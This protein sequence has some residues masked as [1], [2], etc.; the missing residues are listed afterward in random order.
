MKRLAAFALLALAACGDN[1]DPTPVDMEYVVDV[2]DAGGDCGSPPAEGARAWLDLQL[3]V[4]G[5]V[6][7]NGWV[8]GLL[9]Q[10]SFLHL[11]PEDGE[12]DADIR[13]QYGDTYRVI[14]A[15]S[16]DTMDLT[17]DFPSYRPDGSG[18]ACRQR[19]RLQGSGRAFRDPASSDGVYPLATDYF[20]SYC[21]GQPVPTVP[22]GS[23]LFRLD[24]S[25]HDGA[26]EV[27]LEHVFWF[28]GPAPGPD[29][30]VDW[31]GTYYLAGE[32]GIEE[33]PGTFKGVYAPDRVDVALEFS[34]AS[35]GPH[36]RYR[37]ELRGAKRT[38][39]L[40]AVPNAYRAVYR[41]IDSCHPD[42][43]EAYEAT[44]EIDPY[45][46]THVAVFD[47]SGGTWVIGF[48]GRTLS[49]SGG[50]EA[51]GE[52]VSLTGTAEPPFL[53]YRFEDRVRQGDGSWCSYG[54]DV[55]A[56]GRYFPEQPWEPA[57]R[58]DPP[59]TS[60]PRALKRTSASGLA[61][62]LGPLSRP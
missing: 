25:P 47:A 2:T 53:S 16:M 4:D 38:P 28:S 51:D 14:G 56:V 6:Q 21:D 20:G 31:A 37:Y 62:G 7:M 33:V 30:A 27:D 44:T 39:S 26:L 52:V 45:D 59:M 60:L 46:A 22:L 12:L 15:L 35:L 41:T 19:V 18:R 57:F 3:H 43:V 11:F 32:L 24:A 23:G 54:W 42:D 36:C 55:D 50:S 40:E 13:D 48:D 58:P 10:P 61:R 1:I 9:V 29:G 34:D 5:H 49:A 8:P 17:L